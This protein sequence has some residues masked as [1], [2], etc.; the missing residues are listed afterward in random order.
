MMGI[1]DHPM[2]KLRPLIDTVWIRQL[3]EPLYADL[4]RPSIPPEYLFLAIPG[5]YLLGVTLERALVREL[6]GNLVL[7]WFVRRR[8]VVGGFARWRWPA[9]TL[10]NGC[11]NPSLNVRS[12]RCSTRR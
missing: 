4:A 2:R 12:L 7:R 11:R 5:G 6:T 9:W 10:D 8:P 3:C 1:V